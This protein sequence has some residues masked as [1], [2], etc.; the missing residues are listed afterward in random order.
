MCFKTRCGSIGISQKKGE[1]YDNIL[2]YHAF[3]LHMH[4]FFPLF[5]KYESDPTS[6]PTFYPLFLEILTFL[7][8]FIG[9]LFLHLKKAHCTVLKS[10]AYIQDRLLIKKLS[11]WV[12]I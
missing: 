10:A 8:T 3:S 7:V 12:C 6:D 9:H 11:F 4:I 1:K 2:I 5:Q